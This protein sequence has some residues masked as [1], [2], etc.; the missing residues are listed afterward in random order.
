MTVHLLDAHPGHHQAQRCRP[1]WLAALAAWWA[2]VAYWFATGEFLLPPAPHAPPHPRYGRLAA[3][4]AAGIAAVRP[5]G[6]IICGGRNLGTQ[7]RRTLPTRPARPGRPPWDTAAQPA[8]PPEPPSGPA[9]PWDQGDGLGPLV[10]LAR[11]YAPQPAPFPCCEHCDT[12][13]QPPNS[14]LVQCA[15]GCNGPV[16]G[17]APQLDAEP[18][19]AKV[20]IP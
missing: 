8:L 10:P 5:D 16:Y 15:D 9:R 11:P 7:P 1:R 20:T 12:S 6:V 14:H 19:L 3:T 18:D 4:P 17:Q 2:G 13:C